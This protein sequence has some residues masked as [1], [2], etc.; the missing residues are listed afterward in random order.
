MDCVQLKM[1]H[2]CSITFHFAR[3]SWFIGLSLFSC[4]DFNVSWDFSASVYIFTYWFGYYIVKRCLPDCLCNKQDKCHNLMLVVKCWYIFRVQET[5]FKSTYFFLF[6]SFVMEYSNS[7]YVQLK[8][9]HSEFLISGEMNLL[10]STIRMYWTGSSDLTRSW[11]L[12]LLLKCNPPTNPW[13]I[14][15]CGGQGGSNMR[16]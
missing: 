9:I 5:R 4:F 3:T 16:Y 10:A 12:L 2:R 13:N 8:K 11:F 6:H 14:N 15:W 1:R 7:F